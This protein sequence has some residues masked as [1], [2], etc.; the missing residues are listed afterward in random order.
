MLL[1]VT[2][3]YEWTQVYILTIF[4][5]V[6]NQHRW[7]EAVRLAF[8]QQVMPWV[9]QSTRSIASAWWSG[10]VHTTSFMTKRLC[11]SQLSITA[12]T[13]TSTPLHR[14]F[15]SHC[16]IWW[17]TSLPLTLEKRVV[18]GSSSAS[19][20]PSWCSHVASV[21]TLSSMTHLREKGMK[22]IPCSICFYQ[23]IIR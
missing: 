17:E 19:W 21:Q 6:S 12:S 10:C 16:A 9:M 23:V 18:S 4:H 20:T 22:S 2:P 15:L 13:Y 7:K 8:P 1:Y 14:R 3:T 11:Y 5:L